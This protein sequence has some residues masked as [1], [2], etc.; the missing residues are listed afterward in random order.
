ML[1]LLAVSWGVSKLHGDTKS[2]SK[3]RR[4]SLRIFSAHITR[5]SM[6]IVPSAPAISLGMIRFSEFFRLPVPN[7]P[8]TSLRLR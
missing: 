7:T 5:K 1:A 3:K 6:E 2:R 4:I 8:S